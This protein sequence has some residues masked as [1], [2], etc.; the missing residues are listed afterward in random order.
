MG[1]GDL[2]DGGLAPDDDEGGLTRGTTAPRTAPRA[3]S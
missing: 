1:V 2:V 3:V